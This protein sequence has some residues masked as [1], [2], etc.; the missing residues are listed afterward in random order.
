MCRLK[1]QP[2]HLIFLI[3]PRYESILDD[4]EY[5][6]LRAEIAAGYL[7]A[8]RL[9]HAQRLA[10]ASIKR[11]G[12]KAP[13]AAWIRGLVKWQEGQYYAAA[14]AFEMASN[15]PYST[16]WMVASSSYWASRA[17]LRAGQKNKIRPLV[18]KAAQYPHSFYGVIANYAL[19]SHDSYNWDMPKLTKNKMALILKTEQGKRAYKLIQSGQI[20]LAEKELSRMSNRNKKAVREALVAFAH[21]YKLA[22]L[23][24]KIGY[25][26]QPDNNQFYDAALYPEKAWDSDNGY[27]VDRALI[28]AIIRQESRFQSGAKNASGATGLMQLM[29]RTAKYIANKH[30]G[31]LNGQLNRLHEPMVNIAFGQNYIHY[32]LNHRAVGQDLMAMAIAYNAGPGTLS[33]WKRE[34]AHIDDPLLFIEVIPFHE[35]RAFVERV[36]ANFWLYRMRYDNDVVWIEPRLQFFGLLFGVIEQWRFIDV[37]HPDLAIGRT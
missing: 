27:K 3:E 34:Y 10:D 2:R 7:Y 21:H 33:K 24:Y 14:K 32:L 25:A 26:F 31:E 11:S 36:M 8:N 4:V 37:L 16:G 29:P 23:S 15:S 28:N 12:A 1:S 20:D 9:K 30:G 19:G 5:D 18:E 13:Q 22:G 35:T 6:R 17:Y